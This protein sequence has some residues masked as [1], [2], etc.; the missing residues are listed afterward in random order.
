MHGRALALNKLGRLE[1]AEKLLR[2]SV[3]IYTEAL[4]P[5]HWRTANARVYLGLVLANRDKKAEAAKAMQA[6][7][8]DLSQSL[9]PDH[10]RVKGALDLM[11]QAKIAP[12]SAGQK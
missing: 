6:G 7:Y 11:T 5:E 2:E 1:E 12:L 3:D 10:W 4:G 8:R 9:G